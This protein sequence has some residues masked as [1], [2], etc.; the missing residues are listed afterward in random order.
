MLRKFFNDNYILIFKS[1]TYKSVFFT[2][3]FEEIVN[4]RQTQVFKKPS[5]INPVLLLKKEPISNEH[6]NMFAGHYD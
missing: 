5:I 4:K 1:G 2:V 3:H 6:T